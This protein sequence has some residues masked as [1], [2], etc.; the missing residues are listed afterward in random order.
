LKDLHLY[1]PLSSDLIF[2]MLKILPDPTNVPPLN[3]WISAGGFESLKQIRVTESPSTIT[4]DRLM[5]ITGF[6][7]GSTGEIY[8]I[9]RQPNKTLLFLSL[10]T[11]GRCRI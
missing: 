8:C 7:G 9:T 2:E 5:E 3:Q 6:T 4:P 1:S 11:D 10:H